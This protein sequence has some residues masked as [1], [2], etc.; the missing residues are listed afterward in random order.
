MFELASISARDKAEWFDDGPKFLM[1]RCGDEIEI[2]AL[3]F[4]AR[5]D[6]H[7][8]AA[9]QRGGDALRVQG[10]ADDRRQLFHRRVWGDSRH[11]LQW[12]AAATR[13]LTLTEVLA[14]ILIRQQIQLASQELPQVAH[15]W[16]AL[17]E[18]EYTGVAHHPAYQYSV[19]LQPQKLALNHANAQFKCLGDSQCMAFPIV[20]NEQQGPGG[21]SIA[22]GRFEYRIHHP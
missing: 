18:A 11:E 4:I 22:E 7:C 20:R 12:L 17:V 14:H 9:R 15:G 13:P 5:V 19:G 10:L 3:V 16:I 1:R 6:R 2:L 21:C 8:A